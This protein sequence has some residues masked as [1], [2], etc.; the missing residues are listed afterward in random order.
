MSRASKDLPGQFIGKAEQGRKR[1]SEDEEPHKRV[2]VA[3][4]DFHLKFD[5]P[6]ERSSTPEAR[7]QLFSRQRAT[8]RLNAEELAVADG[9]L[10]LGE[11]SPEP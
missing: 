1:G 2:K 9:L 5:R 11:V 6:A 8:K 7:D 3:N 4:D 10:G